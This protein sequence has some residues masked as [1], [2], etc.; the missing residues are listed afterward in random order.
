M[1]LEGARVLG[2]WLAAYG[3]LRGVLRALIARAP[4]SADAAACH[5]EMA[6]AIGWNACVFALG[7]LIRTR[8]AT[9]GTCGTW[10]CA[11]GRAVPRCI[12][13]FAI[14]EAIVYRVH[15]TM[16]RRGVGRHR[17]H[18]AHRK[19]HA[20]VAFAFAPEDGVLQGLGLPLAYA[21]VAVPYAW[22]LCL[23]VATAAWTLLIHRSP[24]PRAPWPLLGPAYHEVHHSLNWYNFGFL[25][26]FQDWAH[27]TL[28]APR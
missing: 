13:M 3:G 2:A 21:I 19:T 26:R 23:E 7:E 27:G 22:Y 18:H 4:P 28:R 25:T 24:P 8:H 16:H 5:D 9:S 6:R 10:T 17:V 14:A 20:S 15:V 12:V 11:D 1:L